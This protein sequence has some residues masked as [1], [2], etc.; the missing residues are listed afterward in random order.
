MDS[1]VIKSAESWKVKEGDIHRNLTLE[2]ETFKR[3]IRPRHNAIK[4][5]IEAE[6]IEENRES[7]EKFVVFL[8]NLENFQI[9]KKKKDWCGDK[10]WTNSKWRCI[11]QEQMTMFQLKEERTLKPHGRLNEKWELLNWVHKLGNEFQNRSSN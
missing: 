2:T 3:K 10:N 4:K 1:L 8:L 7:E 5:K 11:S 6:S 9:Y